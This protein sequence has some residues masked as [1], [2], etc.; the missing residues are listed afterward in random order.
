VDHGEDGEL[1]IDNPNSKYDEEKLQLLKKLFPDKSL[2][3]ILDF[4]ECDGID[5]EK[6]REE[7]KIQWE[8]AISKFEKYPG[9]YNILQRCSYH[10]Q[11]LYPL[12]ILIG[13]YSEESMA[14]AKK[15]TEERRKEFE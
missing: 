2:E 4:I 6:V 3:G 11:N 10:M 9:L 7:N 5:W 13:K 8:K 1:S 15:I 14:K 12:E